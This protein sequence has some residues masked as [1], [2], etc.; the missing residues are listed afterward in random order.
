MAEA[1]D[2]NDET[3][4]T[5]LAKEEDDGYVPLLTRF[6]RWWNELDD[7]PPPR[8]PGEQ[9]GA[10]VE[11]DYEIDVEALGDDPF[12]WTP[13][14]IAF[15][16]RLWGEEEEV[17]GPGGA[18]FSVRLT[19]PM[20]LKP[21]ASLLDLTAGLGGGSRKLADQLGLWVTG[22]ESDADLADA[23]AQLSLVAGMK[24]KADIVAFDPA[25][26]SLPNAKFH[27]ALIR[28][29]LYRID[30]RD[31]M[32]Q[33]VCDALKPRAALSFTDLA[34][35]DENALDNP[36]AAIW[37][38]AEPGRPMPPVMGYY[39]PLLEA[40]GFEVRVHE[41]ATQE[42]VGHVLASWGGFVKN[43][44]RRLLDRDFVNRMMHEAKFWLAR[45]RALESGDLRLVRVLA[46]KAEE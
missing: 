32:L 29:M 9:T 12:A 25:E 35:A 17:V 1:A 6:V 39:P 18:E 23:A 36:K 40:L 45:M 33:V 4:M 7:D 34:L 14:R 10:A 11:D 41:D 24:K 2:W 5:A 37:R 38:D 21:G 19:N 20:A 43:L 44:D 30:D 42:Y 3:A 8:K 15:N 31:R 46:T 22:M 13:E 28:E 27:G 26:L 16:R